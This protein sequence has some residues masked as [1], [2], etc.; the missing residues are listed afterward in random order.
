MPACGA[1]HWVTHDDP[2]SRSL[3]AGESVTTVRYVPPRGYREIAG[4]LPTAWRLLRELRFDRVVSTG[5]GVAIPFLTAARLLG[6][7]CHYIESAARANGPSA[8]G[9]VA[10]GLPGVRLYSQYDRWAGG[11]WH[12]RGSLFDSFEP[13]AAPPPREIRRVVVT[14]GTSRRFGFRR[15]IDRLVR[16]LPEVVTPDAEIMWQT[17][18]T[19]AVGLIGETRAHLSNGELRD[20]IAKADLVIAH[21]GIGSALTCLELGKR[22]VLLPRRAALDEHID[23]HQALIAGELGLRG[24]AVSAEA[25]AV[26]AS[27]LLAAASGR[28]VSQATEWPFQLGSAGD[29]VGARDSPRLRAVPSAYEGTH[30]A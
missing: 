4:L 6:L 20:A 12:Y 15:A 16:V 19:D 18:V 8:T 5:A 25:H 14:L 1:T 27:D 23:D 3:L 28:V 2:Q 7:E 21:A 9:R 29:E 13:V 24:L 11:R 10:T 30:R 17:G 26:T 22:P